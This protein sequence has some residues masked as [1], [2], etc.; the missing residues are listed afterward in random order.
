ML[1]SALRASWRCPAARQRAS[2]LAGAV[3]STARSPRR[4]HAHVTFAATGQS[5]L[6]SRVVRVGPAARTVLEIFFRLARALPVPRKRRPPTRRPKVEGKNLGPPRPLRRVELEPPETREEIIGGRAIKEAGSD[7]NPCRFQM[8]VATELR[9]GCRSRPA[10]RPT[11][12]A[13]GA[14]YRTAIR[15]RARL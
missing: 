8:P 9:I 14:F 15:A 7:G 13:G 2:A 6:K 5:S 3:L 10:F 11:V 1:A 12:K 4:T